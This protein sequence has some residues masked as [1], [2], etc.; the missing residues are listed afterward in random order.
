ML[1]RYGP[2]VQEIVDKAI[3]QAQTMQED[4]PELFQLYSQ[5]GE[6][7]KI[8]NN[9][10]IEA[11]TEN[12]TSLQRGVDGDKVISVA[13]DASKSVGVDYPVRMK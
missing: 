13:R 10:F 7:V 6:K 11:T 12:F 4:D 2:K 9:S 3:E 8:L 1:D 5:L